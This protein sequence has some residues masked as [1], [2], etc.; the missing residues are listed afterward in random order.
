MGIALADVL[1]PYVIYAPA[2][3]IIKA[4][5]ALCGALAFRLSKGKKL[6]VLII[7]AFSVLGEAVMVLGYLLFELAIYGTGAL[8]SIPGNL[9]QA[10]AGVITSTLLA[11]VFAK[12]KRLREFMK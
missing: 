10:A 3:F 11:I 1:S 12:N 4:F 6:S 2:T 8:A 5:I 9:T 7:A